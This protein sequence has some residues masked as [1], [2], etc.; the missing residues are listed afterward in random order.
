M[1]FAQI[2]EKINIL[3]CSI[4]RR[5][6][7]PNRL[8]VVKIRLS[9]LVETARSN[10]IPLKSMLFESLQ[11]HGFIIKVLLKYDGRLCHDVTIVFSR[12]SQMGRECIFSIA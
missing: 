9:L 1:T 8:D 7:D 6:N 10:D 12:N 11:F 5:G 3:H 4:S 2:F